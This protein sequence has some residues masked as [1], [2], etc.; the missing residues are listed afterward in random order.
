MRKFWKFMFPN[1]KGLDAQYKGSEG[2]A[3][4][5]SLFNSAVGLAGGYFLAHS[6]WSPLYGAPYPWMFYVGAFALGLVGAF[7]FRRAVKRYRKLQ[8]E[9]GEELGGIATDEAS[10]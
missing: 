6:P 7:G 1:G 3:F 9:P 10:N 4:W 2:M 8:E 5:N